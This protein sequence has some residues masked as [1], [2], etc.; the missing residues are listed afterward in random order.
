MEEWQDSPEGWPRTPAY[1]GWEGS[2]DIARLYYGPR[3]RSPGLSPGRPEGTA[4]VGGRRPPDLLGWGM[5]A[6]DSPAPV[7]DPALGAAAHRFEATLGRGSLLE[8]ELTPLDTVGV[9]VWSSWWSRAGRGHRRQ[10]RGIGYGPHRAARPVGALGECVEHVCARSGAG[11]RPDRAGDPGRAAPAARRRR[12]RRPPLLGL[13]AGTA[14]DDDTPLVWWPMTRL[15]DGRTVLAPAELVASAGSELPAEQP[16]GGWLTTPVSNGL[17]A[18]SSLEQALAHA[19]LEIVQ[20]DGNGL[21]FRAFD[22]GQVL[23]PRGRHR[24]VT[25][26]ALDRL[27]AAGVEVLAKIASTDFDMANIDVVGA[28]PDDDVLSATACGEAVHPDREVALRKA[29]LEFAN[30]RPRKQLMHGPIDAVRAIAPAGYETVVASMDPAGEEQRVLE[31]MVGWLRL[32]R[33]PVAPARRGR[34]AAHGR[35]GALHRPADHRGRRGRRGPP[36]RRRRPALRAGV[37]RPLPRPLPVPG[38]R[39][40]AV[41]VLVPGL[42]VETVAYHRI[43]ER[44]VRRL[45]DDPRHDLV[46]VGDRGPDGWAPVHLTRRR[47]RTARRPRLARRR[48]PGPAERTAAPAL[49]RAEPAHRAEA[50]HGAAAGLTRVGPVG[51]ISRRSSASRCWSSP[52]ARRWTSRRRRRACPARAACRRGRRRPGAHG[53]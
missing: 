39:V 20:R 50:A 52:T 25:R 27:R 6:D 7:D 35:G 22:T 51:A 29:V 15:A 9:P 42:E 8:F 12:G 1:E 21:S 16:P 40:H 4:S 41:K 18:G 38:R 28:A 14:F 47:R 45:L 53:R 46:V 32:P 17:G 30:A 5:T 31:A 37:R 49:P 34:R 26:W 10:P 43:G 11:R 48:R 24:P 2:K 3:Q 19:V 44:N 33:E 36:R 23:D 13:P